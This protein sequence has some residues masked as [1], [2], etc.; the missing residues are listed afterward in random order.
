MSLPPMEIVAISERAGLV[1]YDTEL[2][3]Y[4]P[5]NVENLRTMYQPGYLV[6]R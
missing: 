5:M 1:L 2:S 3:I 6:P 4:F